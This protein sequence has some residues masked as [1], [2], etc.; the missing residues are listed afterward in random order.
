MNKR[1]D[2]LPL[3]LVVAWLSSAPALA[4]AVPALSTNDRLL[5]QELKQEQIRHT[6]QRV[7]DQLAAVIAEFERNQI[8]GEDVKV[9]RAVRSVLG[10]L[11]EK[12]MQ[13]VIAFLQQARDASDPSAGTQRVTEAYARQ[14]AI[15]L[16][17]RQLIAEYERQHRLYLL[18]VQFRELARKETEA[19]R[20]G[21]KLARTTEGKAIN[22]FNDEQK[23]S[24]RL[25]Q[26]EQDA[27]KPEVLLTTTQLD[28]LAR[29]ITDGP[30]A[31]RPKL[32]LQQVKEGGLFPALDG[33]TAD[34]NK[35]LMLSATGN[36]R[37]A[38]DQMR[39]IA[40]L[41]VLSEDQIEAL[42]QA[43]HE[44]EETIDQQQ[45]VIAETRKV[46]TKAAASEA[47]N[48]QAEVVDSTDLIRRDLDGP[49]PIA[50]EHLKSAFN[51]MQDAREAL[52]S[53]ED[54]TRRREKAAPKQE[55]AVASLEQARRALQEQLAKAEQLANKPE[56]TLAALKALQ[57]QVRELIEKE[58]THKDETAAAKNNDL[59]S[60]APRQGELKDK[61]QDTQQ[62]AAPSAPEVAQSLGEAAGQMQKAQASL[63]KNQ[64]NPAAQQAAVDALQKADQQLGQEITKLEQAE[65]D[66]AKLEALQEK[67]Q[68]VIQEQQKV[69]FNTAKEAAKKDDQPL[70]ELSGKQDKL[71]TD[72]SQLQQEAA[73][74][75]PPAASHLGEAKDHMAEAKGELD[76][77]SPKTAQ[78][79]QSEALSD[80]YAAKKEID[81]KADA[82][83]EM[84]G[85]PPGDNTQSLAD[86]QAAIEKAQAEVNEAMADLQ[87]GQQGLL[88]ALQQREQK[89]ADALGEQSQGTP[90]ASPLNKAQQAA[91]QAAQKLAQSELP[92]A[93]D[94]MKSAQDAMKQAAQSGKQ[95]QPGEQGQEGQPGEQGTEGQPAQA[96]TPGPAKGQSQNSQSVP[97][98]S[99]EQAEVKKAAEALMAAMQSA[100]D[101]ALQQAGQHL[102]QAGTT[103]GPVNAGQMGAMPQAAQ[104]ALQT[105]EQAMAQGAAQT[106]SKEGAQAQ[107][108]A[109]AAAQSLAQ[110]R[111]ALALAQAGL[112]SQPG[113][114][115]QQGQQPGEGQAQA[116]GQ[117]QGQKGGQGQ[118]RQPGQGTPSQRGD[119]KVGNWAGTGGTQ[120]PRQATDG[121][122][123]YLSLPKRDRAALQQSQAEK[124]PQE[125]G[126]LVEQ[127]LKNLSDQ[128]GNR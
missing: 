37:K 81:K 103:I 9:L 122:S 120:G 115:G 60:L 126:P 58:K 27:I 4:G 54:P 38:R 14:K 21:V 83:R 110:A 92:A 75:V 117:G 53:G 112:N 17:L 40:R 114:Q 87:Q 42:R 8:A 13:V 73:A 99:K 125:Y 128:A 86:A 80:L 41:L 46:E 107:A 78:P 12:D 104:A 1:A 44:V 127:Y 77:P 102:E 96:A 116:Q 50:A 119:G 67:L 63:A 108:S 61:T 105:A 101:S 93:I 32:A 43:L 91:A 76:K 97:A 35:G 113:Q 66:L 94:S 52:T 118:A 15:V 65:K 24:L 56:N 64:N 28:K 39:A 16:Q 22:A 85:L 79:K 19:M 109:A 124:Y 98:I 72:T 95:A 33:A 18:S 100:P 2:F 23:N 59:P 30:T 51:E 20:A 57:E 74:P 89:I 47:E 7:A 84:L 5:Q 29:E 62:A 25:Q 69:E 36:Q 6:T 88:E 111:A 70:K 45:S 31:E 3:A 71:K 49:A 55:S 26:I 48:R 34:L 11:S 106:A 123:G 90:A 68:G 10:M 121:S 82:L